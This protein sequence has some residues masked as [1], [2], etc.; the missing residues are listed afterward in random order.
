MTNNMKKTILI[1]TQLMVTLLIK[2]LIL[3]LNLTIIQLSKIKSMLVIF[4]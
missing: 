2:R 4:A 1:L 3:A